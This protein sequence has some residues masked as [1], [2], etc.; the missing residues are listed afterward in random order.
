MDSTFRIMQLLGQGGLEKLSDSTVAIVGLGAVG[1]YV[2]EAL[3]RSGVGRLVLCDFDTVEVTNINRQIFALHSTIN[4]KK[5]DCAR[6]RVL[7]INPECE[8]ETVDLFINP[9]NIQKLFDFKPMIIVDAIDSYQ[10]KK[11]LIK[12]SFNRKVKI[13][14]S[15]GAALKKDPSKIEVA[16]ISKTSYCPIAKKLRSDLKKSGI[17]K[18]FKVVYSTEA[19]DKN[20]ILRDYKKKQDNEIDYPGKNNLSL[21]SLPTI[22]G[23][24]G[25]TLANLVLMEII[26]GS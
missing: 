19:P 10:S 6:E 8:V 21:G 25:L 14:S 17:S 18:G 4:K 15:M 2:C 1:G 11:L 3:A 9:G 12:E 23:I 16:D 24:F 7:D 13:F 20:G 26:K 5:I 22:T